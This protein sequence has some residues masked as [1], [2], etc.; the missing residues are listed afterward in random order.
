LLV[1]IN[2]L[3]GTAKQ[4]A[5]DRIE[6]IKREAA[7][8]MQQKKGESFAAEMYVSQLAIKGSFTDEIAQLET[9]TKEGQK[10]DAETA[11]KSMKEGRETPPY[12][13]TALNILSG[14]DAWQATSVALLTGILF[15]VGKGPILGLLKG[16]FAGLSKTFGSMFGGGP[17]GGAPK[18]GGYGFAATKTAEAV[19]PKGAASAAEAAAKVG[20]KTIGKAAGKGLGMSA[21]KS[22]IKKI[23]IIGALAG[24]GFGISRA[25]SGDYVGAALEVASGVAGTIPG[26]GT[27]ASAAIDVGLA[28]RD[29]YKANE[30]V[31]R[32]AAQKGTEAKETE[33]SVTAVEV[34]KAP[35]D[36]IN[37]QEQLLLTLQ[38]LQTYLKSINDQNM[39]QAK[40]VS[41]T[42]TAVSEGIRYNSARA[43]RPA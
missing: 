24:L 36:Q 23:P 13:N 15:S 42:A 29:I 27:A 10:K 14:I 41:K 35:A 40:A 3:T 22:G 21:L 20:G 39:E 38:E 8:L 25:M 11:A 30:G 2:Q 7:N 12:M 16:G 17:K 6:E 28:G 31:G 33:K 4:E 43:G 32:S 18:G 9:L 26:L 19:A 5:L 34:K 1:G 37:T